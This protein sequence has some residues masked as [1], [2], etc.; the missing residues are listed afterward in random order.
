MHYTDRHTDPL[1]EALLGRP[2]PQPQGEPLNAVNG[3]ETAS[4]AHPGR[5]DGRAPLDPN[6][7]PRPA[8]V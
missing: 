7:H 5:A 1:A 4:R 6:G 2:T 3:R 8:G